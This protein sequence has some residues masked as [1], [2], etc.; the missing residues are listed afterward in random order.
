[1]LILYDSIEPIFFYILEYVAF[2]VA[3]IAFYYYMKKI[4]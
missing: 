2:G 3:T 4:I 1:M